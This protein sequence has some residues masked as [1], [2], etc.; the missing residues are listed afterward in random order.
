MR[1]IVRVVIGLAIAIAP[2]CLSS[3]SAAPVEGGRWTVMAS[4]QPFLLL[5]LHKHAHSKRGWVGGLTAP[6]HFNVDPTFTSF[7]NLEG[8]AKT[9]PIIAAK[10]EGDRL[11]LTVRDSDATLNHLVWKPSATGGTLEFADI[12]AQ[13]TLVPASAA[14][15]V[16][17]TWD[18]AKVYSASAAWPDNAEMT[19][20]FDADQGDRE[21]LGTMTVSEVATRD[22][23]RRARTRSLLDSG[24]IRSA[25]DFYHAAFIFQHGL[26]ADDYLLAHTFAVVAAARGRS[27]AAW[28]AAATL[29]RYLQQI[30]QKQIYGTQF[31][32]VNG[33]PLTQEPYDRTLVSDALRQALGVPRLADQ[34]KRRQKLQQET[35]AANRTLH[36][37][38]KH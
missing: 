12:G 35:D 31:Q 4:G 24:K 14:T 33:S 18:K 10:S 28:I 30:G 25:N 8:P 5:E 26:T 16:S 23:E 21:K 19:A 27:D 2:S 36:A 20:L 11:E 9:E 6:K 34:E 13:A 29:D 38:P 32:S 1:F 3:V 37:T 22:A 7:S 17:G 15:H